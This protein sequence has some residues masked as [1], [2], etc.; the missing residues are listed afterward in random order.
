VN[1]LHLSGFSTGPEHSYFYARDKGKGED[2]WSWLLQALLSMYNV[3]TH[4]YPVCDISYTFVVEVWVKKQF[5]H[6]QLTDWVISQRRLWWNCLLIHW[7]R[8]IKPTRESFWCCNKMRKDEAGPLV[9]VLTLSSYL[10]HL[11]HEQ[12]KKMQRVI[13]YLSGCSRCMDQCLYT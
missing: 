13:H 2:D 1:Q 6:C 7:T 11:R 4:P 5:Q 8:G 9:C 3:H 12:S 10:S